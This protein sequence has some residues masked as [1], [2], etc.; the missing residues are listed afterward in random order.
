VPSPALP[1]GSQLKIQ[2]G[3]PFPINWMFA[4]GKKV[5]IRAVGVALDSHAGVFARRFVRPPDSP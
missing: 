2:V 1:P 4:P 3:S 5:Q